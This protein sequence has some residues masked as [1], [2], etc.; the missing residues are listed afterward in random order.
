MSSVHLSLFW[1]LCL[2]YTHQAPFLEVKTTVFVPL[3]AGLS[4]PEPLQGC[5]AHTNTSG[6]LPQVSTSS[7]LLQNLLG[8]QVPVAAEVISTI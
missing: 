5:G 8:L 7:Q 4:A 6:Q 3:Q 2:K 1:A